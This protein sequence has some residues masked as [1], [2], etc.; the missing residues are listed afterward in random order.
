MKALTSV[1]A[2]VAASLSLAL[3]PAT[4]QPAAAGEQRQVVEYGDLDLSRAS[5]VR[6]LDNRLR[7]AINRACGPMS[8]ADPVGMEAV[9]DCRTNLRAAV[10]ER[11]TQVLAG[12]A[13]PEPI[14]VALAR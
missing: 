14:V 13:R 10:A 8:P 1:V 11:R 9:R 5:D 7:T 6:T 4:A 3:A 2:L 12:V